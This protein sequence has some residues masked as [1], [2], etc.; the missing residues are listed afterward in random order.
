MPKQIKY[1]Q[2]TPY[3]TVNIAKLV[4]QGLEESGTDWPSIEEHRVVPWVT[5]MINQGW[6]VVADLSG[7]IV[8]SIALE[9]FSFPW[10]SQPFLRNSWFY[11]APKF[12]AHGTAEQLIKLARDYARGKNMRLYCG[13]ID[14]TDAEL[15]DRFHRISGFSYMGGNFIMEGD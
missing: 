1:R 10:S 7:R 3:D 4:M 9:T 12:R 6:V 2:A 11:V 13:I 15:K 5:W 14:T 8:G